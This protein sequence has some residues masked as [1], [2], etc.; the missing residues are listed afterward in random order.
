Q[1]GE[2]QAARAREKLRERAL[3]GVDQRALVEQVVAGVGG[4]AK[5]GEH[6]EQRLVARG[7]LHELERRV[8]VVPGIA[9]AHARRRHRDAHEAVT[10]QVEEIVAGGH[11]H[12]ILA[13]PDYGIL[14]HICCSCLKRYCSRIP[15]SKS[16]CTTICATGCA[17]APWW[18]TR[19]GVAEYAA[20]A[21][22]T[23]SGRSSSCATTSSATSR[24]R[25][26][27]L[28]RSLEL[29]VGAAGDALDRFEAAWNR[30]AEGRKLA[31][32]RV[33]TLQ[34]LPLLLRTLTP[35]RWA[36][37]EALRSSSPT[38]IYELAK[39]LH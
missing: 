13:H 10:V 21:P 14:S 35:A 4:K 30:V 33:L 28:A 1:R 6:G 19:T 29:R 20:A 9:D 12:V 3:G 5:L 22:P 24:R 36:L 31:P 26:L 15:G 17:T 16:S 27:A 38:S 39:R 37:M 23:S 32:L 25:S 34:D 7:L 8:G 18:S 2:R 11:L